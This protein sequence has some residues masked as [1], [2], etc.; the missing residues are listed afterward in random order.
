M[1]LVFLVPPVIETILTIAPEKRSEAQKEQLRTYYRQN[2]SPQLKAVADQI[3]K[4]KTERA[5][6]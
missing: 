5:I 6:S 2:V 1:A 3:A 4:L